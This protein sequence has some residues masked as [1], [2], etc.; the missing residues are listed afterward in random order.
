MQQSKM[1]TTDFNQTDLSLSYISEESEITYNPY[2]SNFTDISS[3]ISTGNSS[4]NID[5]FQ[6]LNATQVSPATSHVYVCCIGYKSEF[7][8]DIDLKYSERVNV[9]HA[10]PQ[11]ALVKKINAHHECGYVAI[12][13]LTSLSE[14]L[15]NI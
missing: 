14:F 8:G 15:K 13:S 5:F 4:S 10:G 11:F 3:E 1:I 6:E 2:S 9:L 7:E 12:R